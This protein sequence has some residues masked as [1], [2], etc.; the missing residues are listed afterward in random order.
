MK[1]AARAVCQLMSLKRRAR[2]RMALFLS[3]GP[4]L[5]GLTGCGL[6][7]VYKPQDKRCKTFCDDDNANAKKDIPFN[8][9]LA[10]WNKLTPRS[11]LDAN[12]ELA[13]LLRSNPFKLLGNALKTTSDDIQEAKLSIEKTPSNNQIECLKQVFT[14]PL[15]KSADRSES[16]LD[17]GRC[18]DLPK[19]EERLNANRNT[20][21]DGKLKV[22]ELDSALRLIS[23]GQLPTSAGGDALHDATTGLDLASVLPFR[24]LRAQDLS[25]P[26]VKH[27]LKLHVVRGSVQGTAVEKIGTATILK[28]SWGL[29]YTGLDDQQKLQVEWTP[30]QNT[31]KLLGSMA[32]LSATF[33]RPT[34]QTQWDGFG[35]SREFIFTDLTLS[36]TSLEMNSQL[37]WNEQTSMS[38]SYYLRVNGDLV[39]AGGQQSKL[40]HMK[41]LGRPCVLDVGLVTGFENETPIE[42]SLGQINIC[43]S[44][45]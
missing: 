4:L 3:T 27:V 26:E 21:K 34:T 24:S 43:N 33:Q 23:E 17:Y 20:G 35:Y 42:Q 36:G 30:N 19:L 13:P 16:V 22:L 41:A 40:F 8:F 12:T 9:D 1:D 37:G 7:E 29:L 11:S 44:A 32:T 14:A 31:V 25:N 38:G 15:T 6:L 5:A 45:N 18:V 10:Y 39:D 28:K 2:R